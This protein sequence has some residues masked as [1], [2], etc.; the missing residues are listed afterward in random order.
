MKNYSDVTIPEFEDSVHQV[1]Q[2]Q[3][4]LLKLESK[5]AE[6]QSA[7]IKILIAEID[8]IERMFKC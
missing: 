3:E 2:C 8:A 5:S 6:I 1:L 7:M 4:N